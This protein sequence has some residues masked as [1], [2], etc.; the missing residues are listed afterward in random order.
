MITRD[1][2]RILI[3]ELG[4]KRR[5]VDQM[6]PEMA[7]AI[8]SK[9]LK[10]PSDGM[11]SE[12]AFDDDFGASSSMVD[13]LEQ[14]SQYPLKFPLLGISLILFGKG[15]SDAAITLI[16]VNIDF[17]GVSLSEQFMGVPVLGI[18]AIC[19]ILGGALGAW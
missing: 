1:M 17:P 9:R 5:D 2:K 4:Y 3:E 12:W 7:P 19:V 15:L 8:V 16:K 14:E 13:R 18:D 6:R 11:P 10:C